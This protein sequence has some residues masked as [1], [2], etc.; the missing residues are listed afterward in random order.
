MAITDTY[1]KIVELARVTDGIE[2]APEVLPLVLS[3][4]DLPCVLTRVGA[5]TWNEHAVGLYRQVRT[6]VLDC[7]VAPVAEGLEPDEGYKKCLAPLYELGRTFVQKMT[8]D[9]TVDQVG[10][11]SRPEFR[12]SGV[13][14]LPFAGR[15]YY[16]FQVTLEITEKAV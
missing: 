11:G 15:N 3:E 12:D 6:Y 5:A 2:Y 7:Y 9:G 1:S 13:V 16:G 8:L 14:V 4:A 10:V